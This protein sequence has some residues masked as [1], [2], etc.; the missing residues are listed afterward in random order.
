HSRR[1]E[2]H[3]A[4]RRRRGLRRRDAPRDDAAGAGTGCGAPLG[5]R[6]IPVPGALARRGSG[7]EGR[8]GASPR[9]RSRAVTRALRP[10]A[11]GPEKAPAPPRACAIRRRSVRAFFRALAARIEAVARLRRGAFFRG[12]ETTVGEPASSGVRFL[13]R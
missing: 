4:P 9:R 1:S 2:D 3:L 13:T 6:R 5:P 8:R 11:P 10:F 12:A 7:R